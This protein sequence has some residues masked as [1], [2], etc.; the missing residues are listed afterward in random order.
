M[1]CRFKR[2]IFFFFEISEFCSI[3]FC[4]SYLLVHRYCY[5]WSIISRLLSSPSYWFQCSSSVVH[6]ILHF[7]FRFIYCSQSKLAAKKMIHYVWLNDELLSLPILSRYDL[8]FLALRRKRER[9]R[10]KVI[11]YEIKIIK[12]YLSSYLAEI[13]LGMEKI[14][15]ISFLKSNHWEKCSAYTYAIEQIQSKIIAQKQWERLQSWRSAKVINFNTSTLLNGL[16][17]IFRTLL[18]SNRKMDEILIWDRLIFSFL[19]YLDLKL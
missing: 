16:R 5:F 6:F 12:K 15:I 2:L 9:E 14:V 4:F 1:F 10:V 19:E 7:S 3:F 13:V 11:T 8:P 17:R 18:S